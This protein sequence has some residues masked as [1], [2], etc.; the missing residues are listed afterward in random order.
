NRKAGTFDE[1][2]VNVANRDDRDDAL[3]IWRKNRRVTLE[4]PITF[5]LVGKRVEPKANGSILVRVES[6][7]EGE[8]F[9]GIAVIAG[10]AAAS[11]F[12]QNEVKWLVYRVSKGKIDG[13][14][15]R[16]KIEI[17]SPTRSFY[18]EDLFTMGEVLYIDGYYPDVSDLDKLGKKY[19]K[20]WRDELYKPE[21]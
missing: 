5:E 8:K 7:K 6:W 21:K 15:I 11:A 9:G 2:A 17:T 4:L 3:K 13:R 10:G 12:K 19:P 20:K 14:G 18:R 1:N 16:S